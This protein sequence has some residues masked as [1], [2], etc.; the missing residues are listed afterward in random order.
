MIIISPLFLLLNLV[1]SLDRLL[2]FCT[3]IFVYLIF[4]NGDILIDLSFFFFCDN[5]RFLIVLLTFWIL[6]ICLFSLGR[7]GFFK[8]KF[9]YLV[10]L[11]YLIR[12]SLIFVFFLKNIFIFFFILEFRFLPLFYIILG[13]GAVSDRVLAGYYLIFYTIV[14]SL[15]ILIYILIIRYNYYFFDFTFL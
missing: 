9:N 15:P 12:I 8:N 7:G 6:I 5:L 14:G 2:F 11:F 4:M 1:L 3:L 13:W 10:Y